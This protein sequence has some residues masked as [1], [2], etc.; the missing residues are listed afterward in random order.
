MSASTDT[1]VRTRRASS[2]STTMC[3]MIPADVQGQVKSGAPPASNW[4]RTSRAP[5]TMAAVESHH[6]GMGRHSASTMAP[7]CASPSEKAI[8]GPTPPLSTSCP[9]APKVTPNAARHTS[10]CGS[11][12]SQVEGGSGSVRTVHRSSRS[13]R[14]QR[15]TRARSAR[16]T[17]VSITRPSLDTVSYTHL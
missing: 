17:P 12:R 15:L 9:T 14:S 13:T 7:P 2:S 3:P 10:P 1:R 5:S 16:P 4:R 6:A 8:C 11:Q